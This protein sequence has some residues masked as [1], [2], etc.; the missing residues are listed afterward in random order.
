MP[1]ATANYNDF[2][3]RIRSVLITALVCLPMQAHHSTAAYDLIHGTIISGMVT[4]F[5]WEN[6]HIHLLLDV[7][8]ETDTEHWSIEM[9]SP[10]HLTSLGWTKDTLKSGDRIS[11]IGSR[12]KDLGFR[13]RAGYIQWPDGR[14]L[15]CLPP[16]S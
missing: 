3:T 2:V 5:H 11:V 14:K 7:A 13:M 4:E 6:P 12:A 16:D 8:G 9:E 1:S 10:G 15:S